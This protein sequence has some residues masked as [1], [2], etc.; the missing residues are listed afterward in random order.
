IYQPLETY[1]VWSNEIVGGTVSPNY[2]LPIHGLQRLEKLMDEYAGG[3]GVNYMTNE[4]LLKRAVHLLKILQED[5]E[6]IGAE[7]LHQL[8]RA[9]E[10]KH[11]TIASE[12]VVQ[13]TLFREETRWPGYYY[14]GDHMKLDDENW[15]CLTTSQRDRESGEWTLEKAPLYH[16]VD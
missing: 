2:I 4:P 7:D 14:R 9:W 15:H 6:K 3:T 11:R 16:I 10:L 5:L 12:C 8:Q 13:H 1:E